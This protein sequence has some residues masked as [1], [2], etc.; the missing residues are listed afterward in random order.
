MSDARRLNKLFHQ[1]DPLGQ[2]PVSANQNGWI[3]PDTPL[4]LIGFDYN[5]ENYDAWKA[6][7]PD[8][9]T[10]SSE[11]SSAVSDRDEYFNDVA[12][13]HVAGYDELPNY[14]SWGQSAQ[15]AWGGVGVKND[16]GIL[17]RDYMCG[18]WTWTGWDY[19]GEPTG[20]Q[21]A[22]QYGWPDVNSH[23]GILDL[24]GFEKDR[25]FWSREVWLENTVTSLQRS[26]PVG[27]AL[28]STPTPRPPRP[29]RT[30]T[31]FRTGT[32][33]RRWHCPSG[34]DDDDEN[35]CLCS[36]MGCAYIYIL[37][38]CMCVCV[39]LTRVCCTC[40]S[41]VCAYVC[42]GCTA[43]WT[44]RSYSSTARAP[45]CCL[46]LHLFV[47]ARR[48]ARAAGDASLRAHPV[49]RL[50][51]GGRQPARRPVQVWRVGAGNWRN[52]KQ[53]YGCFVKQRQRDPY[54]RGRHNNNNS[55]DDYNNYNNTN[56]NDR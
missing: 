17:T 38:A 9:P 40:V 31:S 15:Q 48:V 21:D 50:A 29:R 23:F 37:C 33:T 39:C 25:Y 43:L 16:Q 14:P 7:A 26:D 53:A 24:A 51:V 36:A 30:P 46:F 41:H 18:G 10:I 34:D 12:G 11:T 54:R 13:G 1:L 44:A 22:P 19:K 55:N 8:I 52:V 5:T 47:Y 49:G 3:G 35:D 27:T 4:D 56:D 20:P 42:A 28:G 2:R 32:G 6:L 45:T